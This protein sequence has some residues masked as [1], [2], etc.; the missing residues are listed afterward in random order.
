MGNGKKAHLYAL[1]HGACVFLNDLSGEFFAY[2]W[3]DAKSAEVIRINQSRF[4][5]SPLCTKGVPPMTSCCQLD[6]QTGLPPG[7]GAHRCRE[8]TSHWFLVE[9]PVY[10]LETSRDYRNVSCT[11]CYIQGSYLSLPCREA[12][13]SSYTTLVS[14][15][16]GSVSH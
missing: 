9:S 6:L 14:V 16:A 7:W 5:R 15:G 2:P 3:V 13:L 1:L 12:Q 4:L 11:A 10:T 8:S